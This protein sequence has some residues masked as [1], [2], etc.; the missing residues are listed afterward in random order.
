MGTAFL[1]TT[2]SCTRQ[3]PYCF[4]VTGVLERSARE[5]SGDELKGRSRCR[6][7]AGPA[8]MGPQDTLSSSARFTRGP[9]NGP[10]T[11]TWGEVP[12]SWTATGRSTPVSI[13]GTSP[14]VTSLATTRRRFF[15]AWVRRAWSRPPPRATAST[16]SA[17]SS[18]I[19][20]IEY[21]KLKSEN[22]KIN[23]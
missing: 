16:A 10:R 21:E 11:A 8:I 7:A 6:L 15:S 22:G 20:R 12:W 14:A 1:I 5:M 13:G 17:S 4:Y 3:C 23:H 19:R 2:T 18:A 9:G